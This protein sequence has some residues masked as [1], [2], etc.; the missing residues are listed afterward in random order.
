MVCI[1]KSGRR[2]QNIKTNLVQIHWSISV[3]YFTVGGW[4]LTPVGMRIS[5]FGNVDI[6]W[7]SDHASKTTSVTHMYPL[8]KSYALGPALGI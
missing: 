2:Y 4:E 5:S 6:S 7:N 8:F 1:H 3:Y